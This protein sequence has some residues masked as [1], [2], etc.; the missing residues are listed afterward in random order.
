MTRCPR[1]R[2]AVP[3]W[4]S[5]G[6]GGMGGRGARGFL[7]VTTKKPAGPAH[8]Q[9]MRR[10]GR[11]ARGYPSDLTDAQWQVIAPHLPAEVPGR[12]GRPRVW[13]RRAIIDALLYVDRAEGPPRDLPEA[14]PAWPTVYG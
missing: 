14:F 5:G 12:R 10:A 8:A 7:C 1:G 3:G 6:G 4:C 13:P 9:G 11:Q 2:G